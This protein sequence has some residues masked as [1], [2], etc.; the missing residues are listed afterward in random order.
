MGYEVFLSFRGPDARTG[1]TSYLFD[2]LCSNGI[3]TFRDDEEIRK[4]R[5]IWPEIRGAIHGSKISV[6]IFSKDYASSRWCL[7]E[8]AEIVD[9]ARS[10]AQ[11]MIILP[12][13]YQITPAQVKRQTGSYAVAFNKHEEE[14]DRETVQRWREALKFCARLDGYESNKIANG[15]VVSSRLVC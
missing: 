4:G 13:F 11:Q 14:S 6:L 3:D 1:I 9:R 8:V 7:D 12:I 15:Y 2:R 5:E 10:G